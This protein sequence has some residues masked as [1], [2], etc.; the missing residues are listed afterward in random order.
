MVLAFFS[1]RRRTAVYFLASGALFV[2]RAPGLQMLSG[3]HASTRETTN[4]PYVTHQS[5]E[6]NGDTRSR[7]VRFWTRRLRGAKL[8]LHP[9]S[10]I[11]D[12]ASSRELNPRA[13]VD[14]FC[15]SAVLD[16]FRQVLPDHRHHPL[17][18]SI[19]DVLMYA[20]HHLSSTLSIL[21]GRVVCDCR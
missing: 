11:T 14:C 20:W 21:V 18:C 6:K 16:I 13:F 12:P 4:I 10:T 5:L 17:A 9:V 8:W 2:G 15:N 1:L 19:I 7:P 3:Y